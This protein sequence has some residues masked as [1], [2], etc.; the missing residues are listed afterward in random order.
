MLL[1]NCWKFAGES[2]HISLCHCLLRQMILM[3][4]SS[5]VQIEVSSYIHLAW[6][7]SVCGF[8]S[9]WTGGSTYRVEM[10]YHFLIPRPTQTICYNGVL[11]FILCIEIGRNTPPLFFIH[12]TATSVPVHELPFAWWYDDKFELYMLCTRKGLY[13]YGLIW[14]LS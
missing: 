8:T 7:L 13:F 2:R 11:S 1:L 4:W 14:F 3:R 12:Y 10:P 5:S 9:P 6:T